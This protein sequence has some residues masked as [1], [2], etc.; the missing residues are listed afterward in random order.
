[1]DDFQDALRGLRAEYVRES[2]PRLAEIA[3][4]LDVLSGAHG[5]LAT[6]DDLRRRFHAFAGSGTTYGFPEVTAVAR[7]AERACTGLLDRA[8]PVTPA[9]V[10]E[11]RRLAFRIR[12][13]FEGPENAAAPAPRVGR[14]RASAGLEVLLVGDD[15]GVGELR[16]RLREHGGITVHTATTRSEAFESLAL[17][18]PDGLVVDVLLPD[19]SG[20]DVVRHLRGLPRGEDPPALVISTRAGFL[21]KVEAVQCGAEG[22]FEKPVD[23]EALGQRL[24]HL[25]R[26][27]H[28]EPGRVLYVEDDPHQAS[29]VRSVLESAGYDVRVSSDPRH[30]EADLAGFRPDLLLVDVLLPGVTGYDLTRVVRQDERHATLPVVFLTTQG[31]VEARVHATRAGGDE[32]L[33]KPVAP[34]LLLSTVAARVERARFL[35]SLVERDGLT[36]LLTHTAFQERARALLDQRGR[37]PERHLV[38]AMIDLDH[39]KSVNDRFGH[40]VGDRVLVSLSALLRRRLRQANAVGRY[41]GEEFAVLL[42]GLDD[43]QTVGVVTRILDEFAATEHHAADGSVFKTTF[44]AGV[45]LLEPRMDFDGW[46][47]AA[48]DALCAAKA[49]GRARVAAAPQAPATPAG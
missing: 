33:L 1:V 49:A 24:V 7:E 17:R 16:S 28:V 38:W 35:R 23:W 44:S 5:D 18:L 46:R 34:N 10:E 3:R 27:N 42:E 9:H 15:S 40:P 11:W 41:G 48:D 39:F 47:R 20:Y 21:D 43:A 6:L 12:A 29:F 8:G 25:I 37:T 36:R 14:E 26:R 45:A 2:G 22:F 30:F 31:Q 32:L 4:L 19:G 13:Q